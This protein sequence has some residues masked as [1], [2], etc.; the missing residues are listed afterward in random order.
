GVRINIVDTPGHADFGGEV[1]RILSMVDSCLLLVDAA[2]GPMP[3]TKFVLG[4]ALQRGLRPIVVINKVDKPEQR[5]DEVLN[6]I[7]DLFAALDADERQLDFPHVYASAKQGWAAR[8]L[9]DERVDLAPLFELIVR[10]VPPPGADREGP[11]RMLA[12]TLE[13]NPYLGRLLTG[14]IESGRL[15]AN[16]PIKA[17]SRDGRPVEQ[18]R[19]TK[20]LA[21]RGLERQPVEEA[22]AGDI[23]AVAGLAKATVADTLCEPS[24][25]EALP[26][27]PID[28]STIAMT[29]SVNDGPYAGQDGTKVTSRQIWDRLRREAEG[30]VAI[31]VTESAERDAF[32]VSGRG[33]LQLA[34]L[35][36]TMRREGFELCVGRPRVLFR[37]DPSTGDRLEPIEEVVVD[38]DEE[39]AGVV[40]EKLTARRAELKDLRPAGAG[41]QRIVFHAPSRALIGYHG[42]FLTDTRGTGVLNRVFAAYGPHKGPIQQ[43]HTGVLVSSELGE[44]TAYALFNLEDR[45]PLFIGPGEKVY[46]GMVVGEHTRGNDLD[47][48]PLRAKKLTNIRAAGK[49]DNVLLTPPVRMT[50]ERAVAYVADD[51]LVEVTPKAVRLRKRHLDANDRKRLARQKEVA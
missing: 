15:R 27:Q 8:E 28:P 16:A 23:V 1:E 14:R 20:I 9:D 36:E 50:L 37:S 34:V 39:H 29:F 33:E 49:D 48:N 41:K 45:G 19:A 43:R 13:A 7:F 51:E 2:E 35:I 10:H 40:V 11:F 25:E 32:E 46:P 47:V 26:A 21:F 12:T 5:S 30:N 42:E 22:E 24:V 31:R 4:K 18:G 44:A 17:L 6:E 3:Q 38:V